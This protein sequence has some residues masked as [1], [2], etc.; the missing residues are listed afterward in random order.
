MNTIMTG[1]DFPMTLTLLNDDGT[2]ININNLNTLQILVYQKKEQVI[3]SWNLDA[4]VTVVSA[5]AGEVSVILDR[6]NTQGLVEKPM[7][8]EV[9]YGV[10]NSD[11]V[12]GE[13]IVASAPKLIANV[14]NSAI[15][16]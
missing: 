11:A 8:M 16:D 5:S 6:T 9:L 15:N 4:G 12:D 13:L 2:A 1:A 10:V 7:Y 14:V 3:Q